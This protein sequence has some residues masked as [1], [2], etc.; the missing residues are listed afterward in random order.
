MWIYLLEKANRH[1]FLILEWSCGRGAGRPRC[2]KRM[3]T[4]NKIFRASIDSS[5]L[6]ERC[7]VRT[8]KQEYEI[9][10]FASENIEN[11]TPEQKLFLTNQRDY[12]EIITNIGA[13]RWKGNHLICQRKTQGTQE[14]TMP[15]VLCITNLAD[16]IDF[17][18]SDRFNTP[19]FNSR[20]ISASTNNQVDEWNHQM[21]ELKPDISDAKDLLSSDIL[22]EVDNPHG[23]FK[24]DFMPTSFVP[25]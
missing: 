18:D 5:Y 1:A 3:P 2:Y 9:N 12:V 14:I 15:N 10:R 11:L 13:T 7:S 16:A 21:Q 8:F 22:R 24:R 20:L 25:F 6:W 17:I 19:N 4:A 23:I